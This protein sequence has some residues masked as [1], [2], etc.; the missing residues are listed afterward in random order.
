MSLLGDVFYQLWSY[1][2]TPP[3]NTPTSCDDINTWLQEAWLQEQ[4][5]NHSVWLPWLY[6][7]HDNSTL[8]ELQVSGEEWHVSTHPVNFNPLL[9]CEYNIMIIMPIQKGVMYSFTFSLK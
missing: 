5:T 8:Q 7:C 2:E 1:G 3:T 9:E 4:V 6:S